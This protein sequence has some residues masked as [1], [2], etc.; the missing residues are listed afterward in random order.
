MVVILVITHVEN[1]VGEIVDMG[2]CFVSQ[3]KLTCCYVCEFRY[4]II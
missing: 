2:E 3:E 1:Y 4:V